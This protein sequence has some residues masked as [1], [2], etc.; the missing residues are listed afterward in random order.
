[1][2]TGTTRVTWL[3]RLLPGVF[4]FT[5]YRRAWL[6]GDIVAGV[7]VTAYLIPQVMAY[8]T[9][10]GLPPVV[11]LWTIL[12]AFALYGLLGSSRQLSIGPESTTALMTAVTIGPLAGGDP[13]RYATLA[14]SLAVVVGVLCVA[15]A[16]ARLGF[17][18]DLFSRP[19][20]VGYMAGIALIMIGGQ[21]AK[22]TGVPVTGEGFLA[23]LAS[24]FSNLSRYD[25]PTLLLGLA[26]LAL[27][28]GLQW[29]WPRVPGPLV[30]ALLA[31]ALVSFFSLQDRGV[32]VIGTI[33][34]GLPS[35][36]LPG[37][38][39][40]TS[41]LL[42]AFGVLLVGYTDNLLTARTFAAKNAHS[43][44]ANQE[45]LAL[46]AANV[47]AGLFQG[48]PISSSASRTA[49]GESAGSRTQL[50]S[51]VALI[52]TI[53][54]LL[55]AG[56]LLS[57]F[58]QVALGAIVIF[59]AVRLI[60]L[61]GFRQL[62]RFRR[63]ELLLA[64]A[65]LIGV[66]A[67]GILYGILIAVA[68][69][70]AEMLWRVA[71]PHAAIEGFV[72]NMPGM[73]DVGDFPGAQTI[74]G[75]LIYR[76]DSPLFFANA[77]NFRNRALAAVEDN[78]PVRWFVLNAEANVE[79]DITALAALEA[80]RV[81][82]EHRGVRVGIARA[83]QELLADLREFGILES[84]GEDMVFPTLPTAVAAFHDWEARNPA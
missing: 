66:L 60:D 34:S 77:D 54:V 24:F 70:V 46:G 74:P 52:C 5:S 51:W 9:L 33:P 81:D 45:F 30:V 36:Q 40:L 6:R 38:S 48:F 4:L 65:A 84:I 14:A 57:K 62:A 17:I 21:L 8:A 29:R 11:G 43:I 67:F 63:N 7:T 55:V 13:A 19:I 69:S 23:Q 31:T 58:P 3:R 28:F 26:L 32:D 15:C 10:A 53:A 39:D 61:A 20:L 50:Y 18:A 72:P 78:P 56:P 25:L 44:D 59:A 83:K 64:L 42:P 49:V 1:M 82:L 12:P 22:V 80:L 37:M 41:L 47:G 76:Y 68:L 79:I 27:L 71:R 35:F 2:S 73:H 16:I 75:L